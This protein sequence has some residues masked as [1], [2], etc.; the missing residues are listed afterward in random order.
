MAEDYVSAVNDVISVCKDAEAGFRG[1]ADAVNDPTLKSLFQGYSEQRAGFAR[2]LQQAVE[3][4][5]KQPDHA[6]GV[7]GKLHSAWI[8]LKG[9]LTGHSEHQI[10]EE[11]ERGEDYSV[12]TYRDALSKELPQQILVI[13]DRQFAEVQQAHNR[14]RALRDSTKREPVNA[15]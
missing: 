10:L 14:I 6:S 1:A 12:S 2:D 8:K 4:S 3:R 15:R 13:V 9:V 7:G 11:T 5:G